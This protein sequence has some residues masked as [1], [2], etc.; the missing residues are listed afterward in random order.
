MLMLK[1][2]GCGAPLPTRFFRRWNDDGTSVI[3]F[4]ANGNR[5]CH[6]ES[7]EF[8][9]LVEGVSSRI[10]RPI[11]DFVI[12]GQRKATRSTID[13]ILD[14]AWGFP[15]WLGRT[16]LGHPFEMKV[17]LDAGR[18]LGY[19]VTEIVENRRGSLIRARLKHPYC[20]PMAVGSLWGMFE[21]HH[22]VTAAA[23]WKLD[24]EQVDITVEKVSDG[25]T[26]EELDRFALRKQ[27]TI[28]GNVEFDRCPRCG[29][30]REV[31]RALVWEPDRGL[32]LNRRT[33]RREM[34]VVVEA[35]NA[36]IREVAQEVGDFIPQMIA[37]IEQDYIADVTFLD[38]LP[39]TSHEYRVLLQELSALGMGNPVEVTKEADVLTV[40]IDNPFCEPILAGRVAGYYRALEGVS[41]VS[42]WTPDAEGY[43]IIQAWPAEL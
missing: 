27:A 12:E 20:V 2:R 41:T 10:G 18:S 40:R 31:T 26:W 15:G 21:S 14:I 32:I 36:V 8:C 24:G 37:E 3:R 25:M 11:D 19:G 17:T 42:S 7:A 28:P 13:D 22:N 38:T 34:T 6:M 29:V 43:T 39:N 33:G 30:P 4:S 16:R 1:C 9:A 5:V 35:V 23:H